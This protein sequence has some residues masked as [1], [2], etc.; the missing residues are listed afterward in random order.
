MLSGL[1][2]AGDLEGELAELLSRRSLRK[3]D[4]LLGRIRLG[5]SVIFDNSGGFPEYLEMMKDPL[6]GVGFCSR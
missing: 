6:S 2:L 3:S 5:E 4:F 1:F